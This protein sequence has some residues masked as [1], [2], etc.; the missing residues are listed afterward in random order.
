MHRSQASLPGRGSAG[1]VSAAAGRW[2]WPWPWRVWV[3]PLTPIMS[4]MYCATPTQTLRQW[5]RVTNLPNNRWC[6][7]WATLNSRSE[8]IYLQKSNH[9]RSISYD[10]HILSYLHISYLQSIFTTR[11]KPSILDWSWPYLRCTELEVYYC[12]TLWGHLHRSVVR[13]FGSKPPDNR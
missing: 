11:C 7:Y 6:K 9:N 3:W 8:S 5:H 2:R 1:L 4:I 10:L 13:G 12:M